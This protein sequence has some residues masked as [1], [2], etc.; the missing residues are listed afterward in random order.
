[1]IGC[2]DIVAWLDVLRAAITDKTIL[3]SIMTANNEVGTIQPIAEIAQGQP[4]GEI[5]FFAGLLGIGGGMTMVPILAALFAAQ[6][7]AP[8]WWSAVRRAARRC[9]L[10]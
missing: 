9:A 6:A 10:S 5:G 3:I 7:L 2:A 1:M 4:I 8:A